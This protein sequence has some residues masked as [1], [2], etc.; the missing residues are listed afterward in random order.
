MK[1][2]KSENNQNEVNAGYEIKKSVF[3][4]NYTGF[5]F[6]HNKNAP[7]PF[8]TW[9]F[10]EENGKRN[11]Y[12]GHYFNDENRAKADLDIRVS[13]YYAQYHVPIK[14]TQISKNEV[15][16][17]L[18][19]DINILLSEDEQNSIVKKPIS[20]QIKDNAEQAAKENK[21]RPASVIKKDAK[22]LS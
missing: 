19:D 12:W 7:Q 5:V 17:Q 4:E 2:I 6:A 11:Y 15:A 20:E 3:F 21:A 16:T 18:C 13:S 1:I 22:E 14:E 10:N 9:K 8:V